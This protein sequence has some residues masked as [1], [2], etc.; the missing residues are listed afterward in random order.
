MVGLPEEKLSQELDEYFEYVNRLEFAQAP[1]Y[2]HLRALLR[3][4]FEANKF[5]HDFRYDW[6]VRRENEEKAE[7]RKAKTNGKNLKY[8]RKRRKNKLGC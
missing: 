3:R 5:K 6:V 1:D 4:V 7:L 2:E 8:Q